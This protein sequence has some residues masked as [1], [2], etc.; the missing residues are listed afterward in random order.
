MAN[1]IDHL[2][3]RR[4]AE[5]RGGRPAL[6][7]LSDGDSLEIDFSTYK[8]EPGSRAISWDEFFSRFEAEALALDFET[9]QTPAGPSRFYRLVP[10]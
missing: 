4:W 1:T 8:G 6:A 7:P 2:A 5:E 10:R 9:E 3:I